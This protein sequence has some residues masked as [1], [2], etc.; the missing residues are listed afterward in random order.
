M[1]QAGPKK[2]G[3]AQEYQR[4]SECESTLLSKEGKKVEH[5]KK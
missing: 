2:R 1:G 5:L 3:Q 4:I